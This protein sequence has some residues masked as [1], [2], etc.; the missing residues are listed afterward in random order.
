MDE[1]SKPRATHSLKDKLRAVK[2]TKESNLR[3]DQRQSKSLP[4]KNKTGGNAE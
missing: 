2:N 1:I 4:G 3:R